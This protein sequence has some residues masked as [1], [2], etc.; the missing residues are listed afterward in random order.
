MPLATVS[1]VSGLYLTTKV[2]SSSAAG[3]HLRELVLVLA[4]AAS[5][6]TE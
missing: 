2:L 5:I 3:D 4:V 1:L 6:A